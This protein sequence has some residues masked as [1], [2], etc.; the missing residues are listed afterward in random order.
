[1][2]TFLENKTYKIR[3]NLNE[4]LAQKLHKPVIK[5]FKR[6]KVYAKFED[7]IWA[8]DLTEI[9][10]LSSKNWGVYDNLYYYNFYYNFELFIIIHYYNAY[11]ES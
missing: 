10:S 4:M 2:Y 7:N 6:I 8:A 11:Y 1:M 3:A 5:K 9:K